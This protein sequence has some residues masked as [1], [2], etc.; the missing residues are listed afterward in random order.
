MNK[1][2]TTIE[3]YPDGEKPETLLSDDGLTYEPKKGEVIDVVYW[4][5]Y[6][7][8]DFIFGIPN[9]D[10][11]LANTEV[12][13][14]QIRNTKTKRIMAGYYVDCNE[15]EEL[16]YGFKK[17]VEVSNLITPELWKKHRANKAKAQETEIPLPR[18]NTHLPTQEEKK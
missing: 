16:A 11:P 10:H 5:Q 14:F 18:T 13:F 8:Y 1:I 7:S 6:P 3:K 4:V 9:K 12:G 15:A 17:M 2:P